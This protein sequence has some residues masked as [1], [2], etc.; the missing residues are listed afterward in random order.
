M[1]MTTPIDMAP[2]VWGHLQTPYRHGPWGWGMGGACQTCRLLAW[3]EPCG[4]LLAM[5]GPQCLRWAKC[6]DS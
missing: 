1:D 3:G 6:T 5:L 2:R 4:S